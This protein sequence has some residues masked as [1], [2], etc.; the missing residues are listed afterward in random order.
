[1][2][3]RWWIIVLV[4]SLGLNLALAGYIAGRF[5]PAADWASLHR[6]LP[7]WAQTLPPERRD[8]LRPRLREYMRSMRGARRELRSTNQAVQAALTADPFEPQVLAAALQQLREQQ[9]AT[10]REGHTAFVAT[11]SE[12]SARERRQLAEQMLRQRH[13]PPRHPRP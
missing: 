8:V 13:R 2:T 7:H 11:I 10:M 9:A 12:L 4:I 5:S 6:G 1:M 3:S